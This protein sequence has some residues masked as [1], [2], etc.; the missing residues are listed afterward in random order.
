MIIQQ[1][2]NS[3]L[4]QEEFKCNFLVLRHYEQQY[5][6]T[7]DKTLLL[8]FN[9]TY[10]NLIK[11]LATSKESIAASE[12]KEDDLIL[13]LLEEYKEIILNSFFQDTRERTINQEIQTKVENLSQKI[14]ELSTT[15]SQ[16]DRNRLE[17]RSKKIEKIQNN[18]QRN[19]LITLML[20]GIGSLLLGLLSPGQVVLPLK[21]FH[22]AINEVL[23]CNL[24]AELFYEGKDELA[25]LA[26][27][28]NKMLGQIRMFDRLRRNRLQL[29]IQ[30]FEL[31]SNSLA[32]KI[33]VCD[34]EGRINF[35]NNAAYD[36]LNVTSDI[37]DKPLKDSGIPEGLMAIISSSVAREEKIHRQRITLPI[38]EKKESKAVD[39]ETT[40]IR[41]RDGKTQYVILHFL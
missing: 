34:Q 26:S 2:L 9:Q 4:T 24:D 27:D 30:K 18:G 15:L 16:S 40:L 1:D 5:L 25:D 10:D 14:L 31:L 8:H 36:G 19:M 12:E 6:E 13:M 32:R 7:W 38:G 41:D 17:T 37:I 35:L 21:K 33:I 11:K 22:N 29:E 20:T 28:I 39:I 3:L 23:N